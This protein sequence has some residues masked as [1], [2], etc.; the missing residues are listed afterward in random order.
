V[1]KRA[2]DEIKP[3]SVPSDALISQAQSLSATVNGKEVQLLYPGDPLLKVGIESVLSGRDYPIY[4]LPPNYPIQTIVDVGAN[5]GD[6]A[7]YFHAHYPAA[8]LYC[9]EPSKI[10]FHYLTLNTQKISRVKRFR[11]ALSNREGELP[12]YYP[13]TEHLAALSL[14]QAS[15]FLQQGE[16]VVVKKIS[17][18]IPRLGLREI[19]IL[20]LDCEGSETEIVEDLLLNCADCLI[21]CVFVE[22]HDAYHRTILETFFS[23]EFTAHPIQSNGNQGTALFI[24]KAIDA[25]KSEEF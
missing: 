23:H 21:G 19:S 5:I 8:R 16:K 9:F 3:T 20:K 15:G 24:N 14:H 4:L 6:T 12:L 17:T 10:N 11:C 22:Y 18:E 7:I 1:A 13:E 2:G 25:M